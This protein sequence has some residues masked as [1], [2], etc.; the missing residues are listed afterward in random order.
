MAGP[1][2]TTFFWSSI[3]HCRRLNTVS[4]SRF[5]TSIHRRTLWVGPLNWHRAA[6]ALIGVP[7]QPFSLANGPSVVHG[8]QRCRHDPRL[9]FGGL[10]LGPAA[11]L[12]FRF[13][14]RYEVE[15]DDLA[16][17]EHFRL[18]LKADSGRPCPMSASDPETD[19]EPARAAHP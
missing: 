19:I 8:C 10:D 12:N 11:E 17:Y 4:A 6:L 3:S 9:R 13:G 5:S 7:A 16:R 2:D 18:W 14:G 15:A 1:A